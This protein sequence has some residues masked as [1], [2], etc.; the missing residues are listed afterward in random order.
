MRSHSSSRRFDRPISATP[1]L[2]KIPSA[3]AK[4]DVVRHTCGQEKP[5]V[6]NGNAIDVMVSD[7]PQYLLTDEAHSGSAKSPAVAK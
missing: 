5:L 4:F 3:A 7:S 1:H 6:V 2:V